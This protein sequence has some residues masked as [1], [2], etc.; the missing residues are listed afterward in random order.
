MLDIRRIRTSD[1]LLYRFMEEL[2]IKSFPP[3]E[4]RKLSDLRMFTDEKRLFHNN[5]VLDGD[6]AIGIITYWHF[7]TFCYVEHFAI[8]PAYRNNGYGSS[9]LDCLCR[10]LNMPVV[11]E[12]EMPENEMSRRRIEFYRRNGFELWNEEYFQP[13]YKSGD[14]FLPMRIMAYG[15]LSAETDFQHICHS[16]HKEVYGVE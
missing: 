11:L 6:N 16:I 4:Y 3:E 9:V 5:V 7:G 14:S 8:H 10:T 12:V 2:I 15:S 1:T 13:P